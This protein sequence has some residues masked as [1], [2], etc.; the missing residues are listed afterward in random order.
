METWT[1][2]V[3]INA[4]RGTKRSTEKVQESYDYINDWN[5]YST[6][7]RNVFKNHTIME[8]ILENPGFEPHDGVSGGGS[9]SGARSAISVIG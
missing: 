5:S 2:F 7:K 6:C 1:V 8:K 4:S 3:E 9:K